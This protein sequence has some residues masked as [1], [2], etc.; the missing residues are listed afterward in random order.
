MKKITVVKLKMA[1]NDDPWLYAAQPIWNWEQSEQGKWVIDHSVQ[2]LEFSVFPC[3]DTYGY[4]V[5]VQATLSEQN[6]TFFKLR[7]L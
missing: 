4:D 7:W 5:A 3:I 2:P 6:L 1:D